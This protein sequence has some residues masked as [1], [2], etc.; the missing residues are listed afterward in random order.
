M[1]AD[2]KKRREKLAEQ[3]KKM[4]AEV[5][6]KA[7]RGEK[8][9]EAIAARKAS[10]AAQQ[11]SAASEA[12]TAQPSQS[13]DTAAAAA[14][15]NDGGGGWNLEALK[16]ADDTGGAHLSRRGGDPDA[17]DLFRCRAFGMGVETALV[18]EVAE[19][20]VLCLD[21]Q[22]QWLM[23]ESFDILVSKDD[24][25]V[26]KGQ[27]RDMGDGS[28]LM[29]YMI[30]EIGEYEI[31]VSARGVEIAGSPFVVYAIANEPAKQNLSHMLGQDDDEIAGLV[32]RSKT[33]TSFDMDVRG[34]VTL[35]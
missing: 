19:F 1:Q 33:P 8:S 14:D 30:K 18:D 16:R 35:A 6:P 29:T 28:Y 34:E 2:D 11:A 3:R 32:Q 17:A 13:T 12:S 7:L 5:T 4:L 26:S 21:L 20:T 24:V 10:V 22:D 15:S 25:V 27:F 31:F 23:G 9:R